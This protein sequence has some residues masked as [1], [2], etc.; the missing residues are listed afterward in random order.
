[1]VH[2]AY[3]THPLTFC[4]NVLRENPHYV[5][6]DQYLGRLEELEDRAKIG[7]RQGATP[8]QSDAML[9]PRV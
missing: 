5:E 2:G 3:E 4:G 8:G 6:V 7:A 1:M 9:T